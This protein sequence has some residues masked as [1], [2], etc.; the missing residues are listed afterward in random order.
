MFKW[1]K[2]EVHNWMNDHDWYRLDEL[3]AGGHC[4]LCGKPVEVILPKWWPWG[5]CEDCGKPKL[6]VHEK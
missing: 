2:N 6:N 3:Q 5:I 1:I 4:G